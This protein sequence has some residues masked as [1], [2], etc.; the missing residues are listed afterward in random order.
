MVM[1]L[2]TPSMRTQ[3]PAG[4]RLTSTRYRASEIHRWPTWG[5]RVG[6]E[7]E[8]REEEKDRVGGKRGMGACTVRH[9]DVVAWMQRT[10]GFGRCE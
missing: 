7:R 10:S 9:M 6:E 3:L 8:G 4:T 2:S 5:G 1:V